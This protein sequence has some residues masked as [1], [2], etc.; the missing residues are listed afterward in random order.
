M[1]TNAARWATFLLK[2]LGVICASATAAALV[3]GY[4]SLPSFAS[5]LSVDALHAPIAIGLGRHGV[6][7]I[8]AKSREEAYFGLGFMLASDRLF[9]LDLIRRSTAGQLAEILG[10]KLLAA[11]RWHRTM[12]FSGV[13]EAIVAGLPPDQRRALEA[14]RDGVNQAMHHLRAYP[15]EF[16]ALGYTPRPWQVMDSV[17][18]VLRMY[19][20]LSNTTDDERMLTVMRAALPDPVVQFLTP[21]LDIATARLLGSAATSRAVVPS[22]MLRDLLD[23]S[24]GATAQRGLTDPA[25]VE[26][27]S[28]AWVVAPEKTQKGRALLANDPHLTLSLPNIWYRTELIYPGVHLIG[29]TLP[30]VPALVSGSNQHVAWGYTNVQGDYLDLVQI[31]VNPHNPNQYKTPQG[32]EDFGERKES[33]GVRNAP[34]AELWVK[35]TRWGP[36]LPEPLLGKPV[37]LH[38]VALDPKAT[39]FGMLDLDRLTDAKT[40]MDMFSRLGGPP[41]NVMVADAQGN[42][43]WTVMGRIP[44]RFGFDGA[45]AASWADGRRGWSGYVDPGKLPRATNP[46]EG[47]L[48]TANQRTVPLDYP[49]VLGH[50][51]SA[52]YRAYRIAQ[53]LHSGSQFREADMLALQLD[54]N[55]EFYRYYQRLALKVLS[56]IPP[57]QSSEAVAT[58][59]MNWD[60]NAEAKSLALPV[61]T[62]FRNALTNAVLS[63]Y[64]QRCRDLDPT[65]VYQWRMSDEPLQ[66]IIELAAPDLLPKDAR[67]GNWDGFLRGVLEASVRKVEGAFDLRS[68][69]DLTWG[70]VNRVNIKHPFSQVAAALELLLD[71]PKKPLPGCAQCVR[72]ANGNKGAS[73]RIVVAPGQER[74]GIYEMPGGQSGHVFSSH[75]SDQ[76]TAWLDGRPAP[77]LD[78]PLTYF[79]LVPAA[80]ERNDEPHNSLR[81]PALPR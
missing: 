39:D 30:G 75:Y 25:P 4:S 31:D 22:T 37:A 12:N 21:R 55:A 6:P 40:A 65:F 50:N 10:P 8:E 44:K 81:K 74:Q 76:Q 41:Q 54:T 70:R 32:Y 56:V 42:I 58:Y 67:P 35:T 57:T 5:K 47:F 46:A 72:V 48:V 27:G 60:G 9:Q 71:M 43:G 28:N 63:P 14:Y 79:T 23:E 26:L 52:G 16:Q 64:L 19:E 78:E 24:L 69:E 59:L 77:L 17:L 53:K 61:L 45:S 34:A 49:V 13:A 33:I 11:D 66:A 2:V 20:M 18:V 7:R 3:V 62:E 1:L 80:T 15:P 36:V 68:I 29:A 38:W 73:A 51:F